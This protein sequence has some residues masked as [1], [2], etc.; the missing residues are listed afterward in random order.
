M[1]RQVC[2]AAELRLQAATPHAD[3]PGHCMHRGWQVRRGARLNRPGAGE[4]RWSALLGVQ[5]HDMAASLPL[6]DADSGT[7]SCSMR[8]L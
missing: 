4:A 5:G 8:L 2:R 3:A 7:P 6:G 1:K